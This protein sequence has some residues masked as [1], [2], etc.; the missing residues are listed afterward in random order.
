MILPPTER[1]GQPVSTESSERPKYEVAD[2]FRLYGEDYRATHSITEKQRSVMF[3][4]EHC[5]SSVF[6]YH[7]DVCEECGYMEPAYNS[8]RNR[9]C[10][11]CQGI[12]KRKWVQARLDDLLPVPYYHVVFT[13]PDPIFPMC[14]FN[15]ELIYDLLFDCASGTLL[16]FGRDPKWLG[17]ELGFFGVLHTWG[18]TLRHHPHGHFVVP[19]G[20]IKPNGEWVCG[21]FK[22]KFLFPVRGLSKVFRRQ[23][24]EGLEAAYTEGKLVFPGELKDLQ[25]KEQFKGWI[26]DLKSKDWVVYCKPPFG[27]PEDVVR[28][29]GQYTHRVAI[30]NHRIMSIDNGRVIFSYKDYKDDDKTKEMDLSGNEFIQRFLW[31]VLPSG[32]HKIRHYGFLANGKKHKLKQILEY[33]TFEEELSTESSQEGCDEDCEGATC[34]LCGKGRL[35]PIVVYDRFGAILV[36]DYSYFLDQEAR[37]TS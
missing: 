22:G 11:K 33:L 37:D 29:I 2:I 32:F 30:S 19:S 27:G 28:Y 36:K 34:P 4:I 7:L 14:L 18:Q 12:E 17:A 13:L 20:G 5:R 23:F 24:I 35:R 26:N 6:G 31:H 10:P 16:T 25:S 15:Q 1:Q 3:D 9:H 8:C 21:K